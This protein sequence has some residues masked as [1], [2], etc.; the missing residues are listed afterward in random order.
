MEYTKLGK[1]G[2][3]VSRFGLGCM[4]FPENKKDAIAM[5]R[6]AVD[7]G[8]NYIDT[9]YVYENSE[10]IVGEALQGEYRKKIIDLSKN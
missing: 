9:A 8:V 4:R 1:T 7:N 10:N 2:L 6:Y 3:N 5:V